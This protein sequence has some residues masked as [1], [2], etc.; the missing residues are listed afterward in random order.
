[1]FFKYLDTGFPSDSAFEELKKYPELVAVQKS[2]K[3]FREEAAN[4][5][6]CMMDLKDW[7]SEQGKWKVLPLMAEKEDE[8]VIPTDLVESYRKLAPSTVELVEQIPNLKSFAF[9][10]VYAGGFIRPHRHSNSFVTASL[11]LF[12]GTDT[13]II[14]DHEIRICHEGEIAIFDYRRSHA[15][16]NFGYSDRMALIIA[17]DKKP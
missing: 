14:V 13:S 15:V 1:M 9:S 10:L 8:G 16:Y 5:M 6:G 12:G 2:W 3:V 11:C 7:R 4:A 17:L